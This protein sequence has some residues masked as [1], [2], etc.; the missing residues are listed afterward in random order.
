[1]KSVFEKSVGKRLFILGTSVVVLLHLTGG[2]LLSAEHL[3]VD[4]DTRRMI[5]PT[6]ISNSEAQRAGLP[7]FRSSLPASWIM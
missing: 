4:P 2:S 1:M 7:H 3:F 6:P 5:S